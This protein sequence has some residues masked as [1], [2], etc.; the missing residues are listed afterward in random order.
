MAQQLLMSSMSLVQ[1]DIE[2]IVFVLSYLVMSNLRAFV[3]LLA[4]FI[5]IRYF[6]HSASG[7]HLISLVAIAA[8]SILPLSSQVIPAFDIVVDV[9][10]PVISTVIPVT[11]I[12]PSA[13]ASSVQQTDFTHLIFT[14]VVVV[15][16]LVSTFLLARLV[17]RNINMWVR[18]RR[19]SLVEHE[20]WL[21]P[22]EK[23]KN[24]YGI[25]RNVK[26]VYGK[27]IQSPS[28]WGAFRP[29][30]LLPVNALQWPDHLIESTLAHELAHIKRFDWLV[31]QIARAIC[32]VYWVNP[33]AWSGLKVLNANAEI[34]CDDLALNQGIKKTHY[35]TSLVNVAENIQAFQKNHYVTLAM[36]RGMRS[37]LGERVM[38]ILDPKRQHTPLKKQQ[39]LLIF[40][41]VAF[42]LLPFSSMRANFVEKVKIVVEPVRQGVNAA[43][44]SSAIDFESLNAA[45]ED[46][47]TVEERR[48]IQDEL[49]RLRDHLEISGVEIN[50]EPL[51][52]EVDEIQLKP[53]MNVVAP[54]FKY[55]RHEISPS[56]MLSKVTGRIS[57]SLSELAEAENVAVTFASKEKG[58]PPVQLSAQL[59][60][61]EEEQK[62]DIVL[63]ATPQLE[64]ELEIIQYA[65]VNM[66][67]P[68]YPTRARIKGIEGEVVVKFDLDSRGNVTQAYIVSSSPK[69]VFDRQ[70]MKAI[71]K[72]TFSPQLVDGKPVSVRGVTEKYTFVLES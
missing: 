37:E 38:A 62:R 14:V 40:L 69:R 50:L 68:K 4:C 41:M 17:F 70:V 66:V 36:A 8:M 33:L 48:E 5:L 15:Y 26:I 49:E 25:K 54:E 13:V 60:Q 23:F 65:K 58:Q 51:D 56:E 72:S 47:H 11:G 55:E 53:A 59:G 21:N 18:V 1:I 44:S 64:S 9:S 30:I 12:N 16:G 20:Y 32:A 52:I 34:A 29:V 2:S 6:R 7:R 67:V 31:S 42:V 39:A 61:P 24:G 46:Y 10:E 27:Q 3:L 57:Q 71:K 22:L 19:A 63:S 28:T 43:I 45:R 35:A